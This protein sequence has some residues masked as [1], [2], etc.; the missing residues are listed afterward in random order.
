LDQLGQKKRQEI[1]QPAFLII[2][3]AEVP[4][5]RKIQ[6]SGKKP[7]SADMLK[8]EATVFTISFHSQLSLSRCRGNCYRRNK[9]TVDVLRAVHETFLRATATVE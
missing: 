5:H 3:M 4:A 9:D 6:G 1:G 7:G 2:E 8:L